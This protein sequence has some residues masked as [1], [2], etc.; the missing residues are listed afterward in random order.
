MWK[1]IDIIYKMEINLKKQMKKELDETNVQTTTLDNGLVV[2]TDY[3]ANFETVSVGIFVNIGSVN[4]NIEQQGISHF[5][6]HMV[7]KGTKKR[8]AIDISSE[9]ESVGGSINAYTGKEVTAFY[10]KMLKDDCELAVDIISDVIQNSMFDQDEL[11]KEKDVIIQEIKRQNDMPDD[12][13]FDLFYQKAFEGEN[14]GTQILG[15]EVNIMSMQN[16]D[17]REYLGENYSADKMILCASGGVEHDQ[18]VEL[19]GQYCNRMKKFETKLPNTQKY[20]GGV[21]WH[22][23]ELEQSHVIVGYQGFQHQS[24]QKFDLFV[25][26]NI[27][28]GGMSSRLF[29]EIR[30]KRGLAYSVF[31]FVSNYKDTGTFGIYAGCSDDRV[32]EVALLASDELKNFISTVKAEEVEKA[33]I[34]I[35]ASLLMGLESSSSRME[36]IAN[37]YH[38]QKQFFSIEEIV[39]KINNINTESV[40]KVA[41]EVFAGKPTL[42]MIGG[43]ENAQKIYEKIK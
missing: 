16:S 20:H 43:G 6:E 19:A 24:E 15:T 25:L 18:L 5:I 8:S 37:Q 27:L 34:Q 23:K 28:G 2:A 29:Q 14:L 9:I 21:I 13:V 4:E 33:K 41:E 7:F 12:L 42:A 40:A 36:R 30:E 22:K 32:E 17:L 38:M 35:K 31:S 3:I 11:V 39:Q 1:G 26:S 10:A